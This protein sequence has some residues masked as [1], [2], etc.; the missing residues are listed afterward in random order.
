LQD[1]FGKLRK[2][3]IIDG[4]DEQTHFKTHTRGE[5]GKIAY[6]LK[7]FAKIITNFNVKLQMGQS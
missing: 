1:D 2:L 5:I 4:V 6:L 3:Y 7:I